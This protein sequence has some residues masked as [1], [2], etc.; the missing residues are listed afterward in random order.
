MNSVSTDL[1][2]FPIGFRYHYL[3]V[4]DR[5]SKS[6]RYVSS[7]FVKRL[8]PFFSFQTHQLAACRITYDLIEHQQTSLREIFDADDDEA[9]TDRG[10]KAKADIENVSE[11]VKGAIGVGVGDVGKRLNED[12]QRKR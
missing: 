8:K 7:I 9:R 10:R 5:I 4:P 2:I 11:K 3:T 12:G 6:Y 1:I